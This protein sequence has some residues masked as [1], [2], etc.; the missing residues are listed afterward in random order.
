MDLPA[1]GNADR[2]LNRPFLRLLDSYVLD[3]MGCLPSEQGALVTLLLPKLMASLKGSA[4]TWQE[5][6]EQQL[7]LPSDTRELIR[8]MWSDFRIASARD[9]IPASSTDFV[10]LFV[11]THMLSD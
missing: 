9:G 7:S 1:P 3:C 6:V 11:S 10:H 5:L 8:S 4:H 2:Y